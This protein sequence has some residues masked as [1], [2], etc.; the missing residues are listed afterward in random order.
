MKTKSKAMKKLFLAIALFSASLVVLES[1]SPKTTTGAPAVRRGN[2]TGNWMLN[3]ITFE[4]IPDVAVRSFL[5]ESS[6]KCFVGSTWRLTNSGNGSY[7]LPASASCSAKTQNIF[8]SVSTADETFQFKKLY[9]GEKAKN[10]TEG[11]RMI[12]TSANDGAMT[13]KSPIEYSGKTAYVV[14]N[15]VKAVN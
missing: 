12:L 8:W 2:V 7:S 3:N 5:G 9:D 10:V 4:G 1:C 13:I 6:Y 14:M 15:F 11:Y